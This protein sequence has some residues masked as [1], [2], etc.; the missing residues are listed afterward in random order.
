MGRRRGQMAE[1]SLSEKVLEVVGSSAIPISTSEVTGHFVAD[2]PHARAQVWLRLEFL[3]LN[4]E[5]VR[6]GRKGREIL[7]SAIC[8][9]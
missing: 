6:V 3:E 7:W 9:T 2:V 4:G 5:I 1:G 8:N